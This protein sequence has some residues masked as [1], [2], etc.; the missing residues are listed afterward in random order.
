MAKLTKM[1]SAYFNCEVARKTLIELGGRCMEVTE[2]KC[3]GNGAILWE[4]WYVNGKTIFLYATPDGWELA[5]P[6]TTDGDI[7]A[8]LSALAEYVNL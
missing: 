4:R 2:D 6:I 8:T 1:Q 7:A 3:R 5:R